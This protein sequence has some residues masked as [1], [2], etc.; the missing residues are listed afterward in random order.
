MP[1]VIEMVDPVMAEILRSKTEAERLEIAWG[2]WRS[3]R[4]ML[5]NILRSEHPNWTEKEINR[6]IARRFHP[7]V[8]WPDS[9]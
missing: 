7:D 2:M 4:S 9:P 6:E 1:P 8:D 3:A 5:V